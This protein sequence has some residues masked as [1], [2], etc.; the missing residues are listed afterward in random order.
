MRRTLGIAVL[1]VAALT[2]SVTRCAPASRGLFARL[3]TPA[4]ITLRPA[5]SRGDVSPYIY[6]VAL[7]WTENGTR[8]FDPAAGRLRPEVMDLLKPLHIPV[9]RFPGGILAD[10]YNWR[11]G[12]GPRNQRPARKNP[13]DNAE[14]ASNFGTDEFIE[15]C[16]QLGGEGLVTANYGTGT[17]QQLLEW[18]RYFKDQGLP[19]RYWEIGNEVY[20][21]DPGDHPAVPGN[22]KRIYHPP[23]QYATDFQSWAKAI[24]AQNPQS[25]VGAIAGTTNTSAANKDWYSVLTGSGAARDA[26]FICLHNA[27]APLIFTPWDYKNEGKR[28]E[29]YRAM[30]AQCDQFAEDTRHVRGTLPPKADGRIAKIAITEH[31]P[32]FGGGGGKDQMIALLDQSKTLASALYT[33]SLFHAFMREG[34]WMAN[35]NIAVSKWFGALITDT[36]QGLVRT[37]S[38]HVYDLYRN[39]FGN[40]LVGIEV[41]GP[42]YS[43]GEVGMVKARRAVAQLDAVATRDDAGRLYLA[44]INRNLTNG[45]GAKIEIAGGG[46]GPAE[47]LTLSGPAANAI[48]GAALGPTVLAGE[49]DAITPRSS[50]W[51]GGPGASYSF[52]PRSV[53]LFRWEKSN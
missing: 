39:H 47:V 53:T 27:Y 17:V 35:Y 46:R 49:R 2:A 12:V 20:L 28:L 50:T 13:M 30:Y 37:P 16:R 5:E 42:T 9:W 22:D 11:D 24:R 23:A 29:A 45:L 51:N 15:F 33:A 52:P 31:F 41:N 19:I 32:L 44:V 40:H 4:A 26:D 18:D 34:V 10:Y 3:A 6:G 8:V 14:Y 43:T 48:N 21:A 38:Y 36:D 1:T 7:E 25:L